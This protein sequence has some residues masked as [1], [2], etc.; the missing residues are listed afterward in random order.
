MAQYAANSTPGRSRTPSPWA[1]GLALFAGI[2]MVMSGILD[3]FSGIMAAAHNDIY[4]STPNYAFKFN[5]ATWGWIHIVLGAL[6]VVV[7]V[8]VLMGKSWA[9][10]TGIFVVALAGMG[11]FLSIPY[12]PLWALALLAI[13]VF[14]IWGL[15]TTDA[16]DVF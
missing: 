16:D 4:V 8:G 6:L 10:M 14:V 3:F 2:M 11:N 15:A 1:S 9:R 13:D 7:G 12:Y 5:T